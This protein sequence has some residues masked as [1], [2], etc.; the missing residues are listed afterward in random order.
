LSQSSHPPE[1]SP[2]KGCR[3]LEQ[4]WSQIDQHRFPPQQA[5]TFPLVLAID[6]PSER[7]MKE[8]E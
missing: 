5:A 6:M 7:G 1:T 8:N 2:A 4:Q 3:S